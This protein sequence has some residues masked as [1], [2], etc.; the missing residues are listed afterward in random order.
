MQTFILGLL[1]QVFK[2]KPVQDKLAEWKAELLEWLKKEF[3]A[4]KDEV[5]AE[6]KS[7]LPV[8]VKTVVTGIAQSAGQLV[9][10]T[11]DKVTDIIPGQVDDNIIDPI[12]H[13]TLGKLGDLFGIKI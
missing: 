12:V 6:L 7:W 9:V 8:I 10:N 5:M 3:D 2:S 4:H 13:D 1:V 11:T